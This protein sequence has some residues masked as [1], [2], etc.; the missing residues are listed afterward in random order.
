M[1]IFIC[2][3]MHFAKKML[4]VKQELKNLG[5]EADV[6]CDAQAFA[7]NRNLTTDN[8]EENYK[9]CLETDIMRKCFNEIAKS[10][11][12]LTLN[13]SK[14]GLD[15]YIGASGLIEIGLAYYLNKKIFLLYPPPPVEKTKYT[16]EILIMQPVILNG[17]L[18]KIN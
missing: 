17:D 14:N 1:K 18:S 9:Y 11:A 4:E 3:S 16:H 6:P 12:I 7:D 15:G 13:Y 8:H 10:D 2:G 5:Y